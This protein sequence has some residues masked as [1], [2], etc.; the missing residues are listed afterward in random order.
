MQFSRRDFVH[1]GC[2]IAVATLSPLGQA[3]AWIHGAAGASPPTTNLNR[4]SVNIPGGG[5][6]LMNFAKGWQPTN[7]GLTI[8]PSLTDANG[9]PNTTLPT[10]YSGNIALIPNFYGQYVLQ[11]TGQGAVNLFN[12]AIVY[13]GGAA[14]AGLV[15]GGGPAGTGYVS[16]NFQTSASA[17]GPSVVFKFGGL[18]SAVNGGSGSLV[19]VTTAAA[20]NFTGLGT[21]NR[22][23][24]NQ[25]CSANLI[26]GPNSDG[27]WTITN[28][29]STQFTLNGSTGVVS[30]TVTGSGGVGTQTEVILAS[31]VGSMQYNGS[32]AFS[33]FTSLVVC[34]QTNLA[35]VNSGLSYDSDFIAQ[36]QQLKGMPGGVGRSGSFWLRCMDISGVQTNFE[37]DF[38]QRL[39]PS[40]QCWISTN[41]YR[42]GYLTPS[43][44]FAI[45]NGGSD[46]YTCADPSVST[47]SGGVYIDNAI[48]QGIPSATNVGGNPTLAVGAGPA[49]PIFGFGNTWVSI[50]QISSLPTSPGTDILQFTFQATWLNGNSPLVFN[51]TTSASDTTVVN[52]SNNLTIFFNQ[53]A[54]NQNILRNAGVNTRNSFNSFGPG[55]TVPTAQAGRLSITYS[56]SATIT[57]CTIPPSSIGVTNVRTFIYNYLFDG[58]IYYSSGMTCSQPLESIVELCNR[59]GADCWY[60]IGFTKSAYITAITQLF[61]D[62]V[63]GL[64]SGLRL[65]YEAWNEIWNPGANPHGQL[66]VLGGCFGWNI[67]ANLADGGYT[68]LRTLQYCT[69]ASSAWTG[70]GR[71]ASDFWQM[72]MAQQGQDIT[73][74]YNL[75]QLGGQPFV[76]SNSFYATYGGLNGGSAPD[77]STAPNRPV[78]FPT[79]FIGFAPYWNSK[80]LADGS[81]TSA[82]NFLG[83]VAQQTNL[84]QA[85][86]DYANGNTS[87]AFTALVNQFNRVGT[88]GP[89]SGA[90]DF[91]SMQNNFTQQEAIAASY[92]SGRA[93]KV[94]INHYEGGS[95]FGI[96][97]NGN[98]GVNSIDN[99]AANILSADITALANRFSAL[100]WTTA[101]LIPFTSSGT[102]N[103]TEMATMVLVMLQGWKYDLNANGTAAGLNSYDTM[104]KTSYFQALVNTSGANRETHA[105]QYGYS[106]SNWGLM[107]LAYNQTTPFYGNFNA[108]AEFNT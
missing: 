80:Y 61:A 68:G 30:P 79:V 3:Q 27:S 56:G 66:Q 98:S 44:S 104:I 37:G 4:T 23:K 36:L 15:S 92:D 89:V 20:L 93:I 108:I 43:G 102:G 57:P 78:D 97:N 11:Y 33:G 34:K 85:A 14:V 22:V 2:T 16:A 105:G 60:N 21:G 73:S 51:Y 49:K 75:Y 65:G 35:A 32:V 53:S 19:T 72:N 100:G 64:T 7:G 8:P 28:V 94:G 81:F 71:N 25:G 29:S 67:G 24:F 41:N 13:S 103:L 87:T 45:T 10:N 52:L 39:T 62:S 46:N 38:S 54:T 31:G 107:Y 47:L 95:S 58:W 9:Y 77:H 18:V 59:V 69:V 70:K 12:P 40:S 17:T 86:L 42:Q 90:A 1:A 76:T 91:V 26:N 88:V 55:F 48:V 82:S 101:Q 96:G 63:T 74:G 106:G 50:L 84:L 6:G 83:T 99:Q 5:V